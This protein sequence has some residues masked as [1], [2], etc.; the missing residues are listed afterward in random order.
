MT[1]VGSVALD[2]TADIG[3]LIRETNRAKGILSAFGRSAE[4]VGGR[5]ESFGTSALALGKKLA[6]VTGAL[7]A[8]TGAALALAKS[9]AA[10]GDKIGDAAAAAGVSTDYFQ[11]MAFAMGAAADMS[12]EEFGAAL[13]RLTK[14]LG[15][16][17]QGSETAIAA[18]E[19]IGISQAD[20]ASGAISTEEAFDAY[21]A[22]LAAIR[23]P[24]LAAAI[25]TDLFGKAGAGMG[26][27]LVGAS[28]KVDELRKRAQELGIVMSGD[29]IEASD[30]FDERWRELTATM[31]RVKLKLAEELLPIF[32]DTLIP[33]LVDYAA[34]AVMGLAMAFGD[35]VK[36][37]GETAAA[38]GAFIDGVLAKF[39]AFLA[40]V[41]EVI[42]KV[43]EMGRA[44]AEA[45][46]GGSLD[47]MGDAPTIM[48]DQDP[49]A[50]W[51]EDRFGTGQITGG[52]MSSQMMGASVVNGMV[53]GATQAMAEQEE[54]LRGLFGRIPAIAQEIL[55]I[56]SPSRVFEGIGLNIG[57]G[58]ASGITQT[59][60]MVAR[61]VGVLSESA[62]TSTAGMVQGVLGSLGT[63]FQGSKKFAAAQA[64]VN[65]W[66]GASE[67]LKLPFP[68]NLAAFAKVLATGLGA[69]RNI[70]SATPGGGGGGAVGG[71]AVASAAP[72]ATQS[73]LD[74]R[75]NLVGDGDYVRKSDVSSLLDIL[76]KEAGDKGY[77]LMVPA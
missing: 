31:E 16:A 35:L 41:Q 7:A 19:A 66:A 52:A 32:T 6:I 65:A 5:L 15:E 38:V 75:L 63:L 55:Q 20:I 33:F 4:G 64:L 57:E 61:A 37:V 56:N 53:L 70:K 72:A 67:A 34:P 42:A 39:Q 49:Q 40:K 45:F 9:A 28:A 23:D 10:T 50:G 14:T 76:N 17:R 69:V 77:R 11:E 21:I 8:A 74:V 51:M 26:G 13:T 3:P 27:Q 59:Q 62:T 54:T 22:K 44:I 43:R 48:Q 12:Q 29:F 58:L 46:S 47:P 68:K 25:S 71:G 30:R 24:A 60:D 73:P 18:F 36:W 1:T 2:I